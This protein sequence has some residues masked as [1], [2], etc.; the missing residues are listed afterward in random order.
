[1]KLSAFQAIAVLLARCLLLDPAIVHSA[2]SVTAAVS[3][4][5]IARIESPSFSAEAFAPRALEN[6]NT[7]LG[8]HQPKPG[9][10]VND[11]A[12]QQPS[13][14]NVN[15]LGK[16]FWEM[17]REEFEAIAGGGIIGP[18]SN[19]VQAIDAVASG[20]KP[21]ATVTLP[22]SMYALSLG[23]A[24][25]RLPSMMDKPDTFPSPVYE[26]GF[27]YYEVYAVYRPGDDAA[28]HRIDAAFA[29]IHELEQTA[30]NSNEYMGQY[31]R[32][33]VEEGLAYGYSIRDIAAHIR[34][35]MGGEQAHELIIVCALVAGLTIPERILKEYPQAKEKAH[36]I[37]L[38]KAS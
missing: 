23:L 29:K 20:D 34:R 15:S 9:R 21:V 38:K 10:L 31:I 4:S 35:K 14:S 24:V 5:D 18:Y 25:I 2:Y 3:A 33:R 37:H 16:D 36:S 1:M 13:E 19:N 28:W 6:Q 12:N 30:I 22:E 26:D 7:A 17:T 8:L 27:G 11:V 32:A